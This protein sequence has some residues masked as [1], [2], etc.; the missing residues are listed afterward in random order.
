MFK[1]KLGKSTV[2]ATGLSLAIMASAADR[3]LSQGDPAP[4]APAAEDL[5]SSTV[6]MP[7]IQTQNGISYVSGGVGYLSQ[8]A[9]KRLARDFNLR[10]SFAVRDGSYLADIPVTIKYRQGNTVL[11]TVSPEPLFYASL[12]PGRYTVMAS[13]NG[14]T[15]TRQVSVGAKSPAVINFAW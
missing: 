3:P 1:S 7:E 4:M 11:E 15:R 9:M 10:L 2:L 14:Q 13:A 6:E 12:K 5:A 8:Q